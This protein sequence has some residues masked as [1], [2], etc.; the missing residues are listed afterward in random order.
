MA[1]T[2]AAPWATMAGWYRMNGHVTRVTRSTE[3]VVATTAPSALQAS[4]LSVWRL[5]HGSKWSDINEEVEPVVLGGPGLHQH[6][7]R[8]VELG[9]EGESVA[10]HGGGSYTSATICRTSAIRSRHASDRRW[11]SA[12]LRTRT[13]V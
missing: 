5:D 10:G 1:C 2:V 11:S 8:S 3:W 12:R 4:G 9:E 7:L 13:S 6:R